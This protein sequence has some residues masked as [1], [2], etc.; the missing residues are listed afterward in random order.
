[1]GIH[2]NQLSIFVKEAYT[3][4]LIGSTNAFKSLL[5]N[6]ALCILGPE[7]HKALSF[8]Q[9]TEADLKQRIEGM[10]L[11]FAVHDP[12]SRTLSTI[13]WCINFLYDRLAATN[14]RRTVFGSSNAFLTLN[15]DTANRLFNNEDK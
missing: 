9:I 4:A 12:C 2:I 13:E 8:G 5:V 14:T 1:M 3:F 10:A 11:P 6:M 7:A 15:N